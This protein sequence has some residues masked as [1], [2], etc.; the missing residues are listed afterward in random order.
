M[1]PK[2]E[3]RTSAH[4]EFFLESQ[5]ELA[6]LEAEHGSPDSFFSVYERIDRRAKPVMSFIDF[7]AGIISDSP[8]EVIASLPA[9]EKAYLESDY[10]GKIDPLGKLGLVGN[11]T[12]R[13]LC[14][15]D[16]PTLNG[17]TKAQMCIAA[18]LENEISV[19]AVSATVKRIVTAPDWD[20][21]GPRVQFDW[22]AY[23]LFSN[24]RFS[25][26]LKSLSRY[27]SPDHQLFEKYRFGKESLT[28]T[29]KRFLMSPIGYDAYVDARSKNSALPDP[30]GSEIFRMAQIANALAEN[31]KLDLARAWAIPALREHQSGSEPQTIH[32]SWLEE[33]YDVAIY[34]DGWR[35]LILNT[36]ILA[37]ASFNK[38][39][40]EKTFYKRGATF[41][42]EESGSLTWDRIIGAYHGRMIA[43]KRL[44]DQA[45]AIADAQALT[46]FVGYVLNLQSF[47]RNETRDIIARIAR[48]A[49][50]EALRTLLEGDTDDNAKREA[51]FEIAQLLNQTRTGATL[52]RVGARLSSISPDLADLA[53]RR[54]ARR[55][56][57]ARTDNTA[58]RSALATE[59]D[60]LDA[61]IRKKFPAY[62]EMAG[63]STV[64]LD[65]VRALLKEDE[66]LISFVVLNDRIG[67]VVLGRE[68][69]RY[70]AVNMGHEELR[71]Q[72]EAIRCGLDATSWSTPQD[73]PGD[74]PVERKQKAAQ[75]DRA[76][77]C[78]AALGAA[79]REH[80]GYSELP[81]SHDR[82]YRLYQALFGQ[83]EDLI[84][85]KHLLIVPTG[86]LAQLPFH[87][88]VTQPP[89]EPNHKKVHWLVRSHAVTVL[90][91]VSS[92]KALRGVAKPSAATKPMIGFGNPL[93]DGQQ[94]DPDPVYANIFKKRAQLA[95][96]NQQCRTTAFQ[97]VANLFGWHRG[98][99]P[100]ETRHGLANV[101]L[102][103]M[104]TP[105]PET[106][107]ELC[108][109]ARDIK[110]DNSDIHLGKGVNEHEVK[111]L[112]A[113]GQLSQYRIV[114]FATH[115]TLAGELKGSSEPGLILTPPE[116]ATENDDGY[117]SAS[118]IANLKLDADWVILSACNTAGGI[119]TSSE[120]LSG[121]AR[122]FF[123]AQA[124]AL[125][126]SH[127]QVASTSTVKLI[128]KTVQT[129]AEKGTRRAEGLRRAMLYLIDEGN[130]HEAHPTF[131]APFIVVGEG[132]N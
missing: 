78:L 14:I 17:I 115:G 79:P 119:D 102:I 53:K 81:F 50:A 97:R 95:R 47:T 106:A 87:V 116:A 107:T 69:G 2:P 34:H 7:Y 88:L 48:P 1:L 61:E 36:P 41:N 77:A 110:A 30:Q 71:A 127:W 67:M 124:R 21:K 25:S 42:E 19:E 93:L 51:V 80:D 56:E 64:S 40:P 130:P 103:R 96:D 33:S 94:N 126:V 100:V 39:I 117:L 55:D 74:P 62:V 37:E 10:G 6:E 99:R 31:G 52:A 28:E 85:D 22:T 60:T 63:A 38:A 58:L 84:K 114:H 90:P 9:T 104:Q 15:T 13:A 45:G 70:R 20:P 72:V 109:V 108:E 129:M 18:G 76:E 105:L 23:E 89:A 46:S 26:I 92:L 5:K 122:A 66:I 32:T 8:T 118:E 27:I 111:A 128:T 98:V 35:W 120:M 91:A 65:Q 75:R 68:G 57:W 123:F 86:P 11:A 121:L 113:S 125:L 83:F 43:R 24:T 73:L 49:L 44:G 101:E 16:V 112:S 54:E 3:D 12:A 131:W 4:R 82:A 29:E 132:S 59:I